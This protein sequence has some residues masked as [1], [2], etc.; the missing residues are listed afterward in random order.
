MS[1]IEIIIIPYV[2]EHNMLT[3]G[4]FFSQTELELEIFPF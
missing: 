1:I 2:N 4:E 3:L